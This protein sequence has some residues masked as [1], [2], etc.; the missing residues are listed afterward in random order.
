MQSFPC[1][2]SRVSIIVVDCSEDSPNSTLFVLIAD[3]FKRS[4]DR[5]D[6]V[7]VQNNHIRLDKISKLL[8]KIKRKNEPPP[9]YCEG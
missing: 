9:L 1:E 7:N 2:T 5:K 8:H 6:T 4:R 3:R